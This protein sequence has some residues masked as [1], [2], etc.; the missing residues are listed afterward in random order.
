MSEQESDQESEYRPATWA[1]LTRYA[2]RSL[3]Q[4]ERE[5]AQRAAL[6]ALAER[7]ERPMTG[8]SNLDVA[9]ELRRIVE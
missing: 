4:N 6:L 8:M 2:A 9:R 5:G 7:L 3:T 1:D